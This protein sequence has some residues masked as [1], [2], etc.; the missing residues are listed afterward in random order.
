MPPAPRAKKTGA[1]P[2]YVKSARTSETAFLPE[3]DSGQATT[4]ASQLRLTSRSTKDHIRKVSKASPDM[5]S[6]VHTALRLGVSPKYRI[7]SR[8]L[9]GTVNVDG[10]KL[11]QQLARR[12]DYMGTGKGFNGF[13]TI[14]SAAEQLGKELQLEGACCL[15]LVLG[16]GRLPEGLAPL[17]VST[18]KFRYK[19]GRKVPYQKLG[20]SEIPLDVPTFFY[21]SLDQDLLEPYAESPLQS[22]LQPLQ[23]SMDFQADLR[24][25]FRRAIHPRLKGTISYDDWIKQVPPEVMHDKAKLATY[26]RDTIS[27]LTETLDGLNPEDALVNF[28]TVEFD[29]LTGGN[30]SLSKE[31]EVLNGI[32]NS[33]TAAGVKTMPVVLGHGVGSQN[34]A[35]SESMLYLKSVE[36]GVQ[37]KLGEVFSRLFTTAIRLF[38]VDAV[39]DFSFD[40]ISLRPELEMEAFRS[41][42]QSRI[43]EQLSLGTISDVEASL[44]LSGSLPEPGAPVLSGTGFG[45]K[46]VESGNP[47]SST[48]NGKGSTLNQALD[49]DTPTQPKSEGV[50]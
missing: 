10:T 26:M 3:A 49:P 18:V 13:P 1:L 32:I 31:Y 37:A 29:Y 48:S 2:T 12:I 42:K 23:A 16:Q 44:E 35:S 39:V 22:S 15:E 9:D 27:S 17:A 14:R 40:Y 28:D 6:A 7:I 4:D 33:K 41:M 5:S 38:G 25:V 47:A 50:I 20:D 36:T 21:V 19:S 43:Y 8:N 24:R 45:V 34:I 46:S 30:N 11:A